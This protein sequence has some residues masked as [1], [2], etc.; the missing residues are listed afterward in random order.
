MMWMTMNITVV[1]IEI[2]SSTYKYHLT[3]NGLVEQQPRVESS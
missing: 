1:V 3:V 2:Q